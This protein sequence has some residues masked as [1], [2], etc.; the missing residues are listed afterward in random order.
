MWGDAKA[1]SSVESD[2]WYRPAESHWQPEG[3]SPSLYSDFWGSRSSSAGIAFNGDQVVANLSRGDDDP[4]LNEKTVTLRA[5]AGSIAKHLTLV[6]E[7]GRELVIVTRW[8]YGATTV[9]S[10]SRDGA[11][12]SYQLNVD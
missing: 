10:R 9:V 12:V 8:T 3:C 1:E 11:S 6:D 7:S 2:R 4:E 5:P